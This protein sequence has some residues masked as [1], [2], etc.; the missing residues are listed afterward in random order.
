MEGPGVGMTKKELRSIAKRKVAI[1]SSEANVKMMRVVIKARDLHEIEN[2][3]AWA[4][5]R[6]ELIRIKALPIRARSKVK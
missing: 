4:E 2:G 5:Y 6:A 3:K 1:A